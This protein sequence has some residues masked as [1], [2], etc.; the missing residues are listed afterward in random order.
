MLSAF[1]TPQ[2]LDSANGDV[3]PI[4]IRDCLATCS[5]LPCGTTVEHQNVTGGPGGFGLGRHSCYEVELG[6]D[7]HACAVTGAPPKADLEGLIE[8]S[9]LDELLRVVPRQNV[10]YVP[11]RGVVQL[12]ADCGS[13]IAQLPATPAAM[14]LLSTE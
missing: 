8:R 9:N 4:S 1:S 14:A 13:V 3:S 7:Y 2:Q 10:A 11:E 5:S 6:C 12:M